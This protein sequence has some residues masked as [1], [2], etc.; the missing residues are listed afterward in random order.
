MQTRH[1]GVDL[2]V[3]A[4]LLFFHSLLASLTTYWP[5]Q[6]ERVLLVH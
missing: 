3:E 6:G 1:V 4:K 5:T 2:S